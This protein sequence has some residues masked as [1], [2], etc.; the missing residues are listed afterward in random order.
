[1]AIVLYLIFFRNFGEHVNMVELNKLDPLITALVDIY[2]INNN[3]DLSRNNSKKWHKTLFVVLIKRRPKGTHASHLI[4]IH[5]SLN[6]FNYH[7]KIFWPQ[8]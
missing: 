6:F 7:I 4:I 3:W 1:M 8:R 2:E 5:F